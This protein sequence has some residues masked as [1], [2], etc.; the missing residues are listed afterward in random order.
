MVFEDFKNFRNRL[1][2]PLPGIEAQFRMA[3]SYRPGMDELGP[4]QKAGVILLLY[5]KNKELYFPLIERPVYNGAH[6]GQIS[7]PG[8][9][10]EPE[11]KNLTETALRECE[12]EIGVNTS[13]IITLGE[14]THLYIP[15]SKYEVYPVVGYWEGDT[16][17]RPQVN[18]V[19]SIIE[20]PLNMILSEKCIEYKKVVFNGAEETIPFYNISGKMVWGA[21]AMILSEFIQIWNDSLLDFYSETRFL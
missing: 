16:D 2:V 13:E 6:S 12:E 8:G 3:P 20:V 9:K 1:T 19:V 5:K 21:T 18:E 14:L 11:D 7:F 15:V 4:R 17:F 10:Q